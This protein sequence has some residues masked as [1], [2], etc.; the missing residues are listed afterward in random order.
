MGAAARL[1][2]GHNATTPD[3]IGRRVSGNIFFASCGVASPCLAATHRGK[4]GRFK[5]AWN[6]QGRIRTCEGLSHQIYS[7][8]R[9]TASVPT[10]RHDHPDHRAP[11]PGRRPGQCVAMLAERAPAFNRPDRLRFAPGTG[12]DLPVKDRGAMTRHPAV[13][14]CAMLCHALPCRVV[15]CRASRSAPAPSPHPCP[16]GGPLDPSGRAV[17]DRPPP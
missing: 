16:G 9:L 8:A 17:D 4:A 3:D 11:A 15:P 10:R 1:T 13:P 6:G 2:A 5:S 14:C 7:L 12:I